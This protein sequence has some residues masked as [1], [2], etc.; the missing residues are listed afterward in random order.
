ML[1]PAAASL[2]ADDS[3]AK[4]LAGKQ[5]AK[6]YNPEL[7]D[8]LLEEGKPKLSKA[9][10]KAALDQLVSGLMANIEVTQGEQVAASLATLGG[11][12]SG[13]VVGEAL[14]ESS[15]EIWDSW[16]DSAFVLLRAGYKNEALAFFG[17][18]A[19]VFPSETQRG[20]C[21]VGLAEAQPDQAYDL[22]MKMADDAAVGPE[23]QNAAL[24]MLGRM[25][26]SEKCPD[27]KKVAIIEEL[28]K[29]GG[30]LSGATHREAVA[31]GLTW[32]NDERA[33]EPLRKLT[34]GMTTSDETKRIAK[35]GLL[36]T[37][38][39]PEMPANVAKSLG[40]FGRQEEEK[41]WA[42]SLLIEAGEEKGYE[43]AAKEL[44]KKGKGFFGSKNDKDYSWDIVRTLVRTGGERAT[45]VLAEAIAKGK[46][47]DEK[48]AYMAIG[49]AR[50]G[51]A[52]QIEMVR[53][54]LANEK[55]PDLRWQ[56]AVAL[57][58]HGDYSGI[59][60]LASLATETSSKKLGSD[61][62][63][64][65]PRIAYALGEIDHADGVPILKGLLAD[66]H[67]NVRLAAAYALM[68]MKD[69]AAL[70]GLLAALAVDYGKSNAG[71]RDP[72]VH[73]RIVRRALQQ[74]G[75]EARTKQ[76]LRDGAQSGWL[77]VRFLS[78]AASS[79]KAG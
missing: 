76:L 44:Q 35:R 56:A 66:E 37:Y 63:R 53:A 41:F 74:F 30:G 47:P 34:G 61:P 70:D 52:S 22:L 6:A 43:W 17:H 78:L 48:K 40:G 60:V 69:V 50:L 42:A 79:G 54:A 49:L 73:A 21:I 15:S 39:D 59:P 7:L 10:H 31:L 36:L 1:L 16:V 23:G 72:Q 55:A 28:T 32:A 12:L 58:R 9:Q 71:P 24:R 18:C 2:A 25:A 29:R 14:R 11:L 8:Y 5:L 3:V 65:R 19:K 67:A 13:G 46:A 26:G 45:Q 64:F 62:E 20:R 38:K 27:E 4:I 57:A 68:D 33:I 51:D 77:S 75:K